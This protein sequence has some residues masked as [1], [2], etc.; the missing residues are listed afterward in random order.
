M[1]LGQILEFGRSEELIKNPLHTYIKALISAVPSI[2]PNWV[3]K[4]LS[5][6]CE[7]G[8]T[9]NPKKG[10]RFYGRCIFRK[11]VCKEE[12]PEMINVDGRYYLCHFTQEELTPNYT[13]KEAENLEEGDLR[14]ENQDD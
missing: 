14:E 11:D 12:D 8:S 6:V 5:I 1:H 10:C 2:G 7:I 3:N 9:I 4:N 13:M